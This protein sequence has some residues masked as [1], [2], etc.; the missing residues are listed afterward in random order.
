LKQLPGTPD[1]VRALA[2]HGHR[3]SA[4]CRSAIFK[5]RAHG[6]EE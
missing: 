2:G 3:R 1:L 5:S 4:T 6:E